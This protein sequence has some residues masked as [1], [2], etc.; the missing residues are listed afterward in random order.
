MAMVVSALLSLVAAVPAFAEDGLASQTKTI[1]VNNLQVNGDNKPTVSIYRIINCNYKTD[2]EDDAVDGSGQVGT[3]AYYWDSAIAAKLLADD[4]LKKWVSST[5]T[6][7]NKTYYGVADDFMKTENSTQAAAVYDQIRAWIGLG[8]AGGGITLTPVATPDVTVA[9]GATTGSVTYNATMGGYLIDVVGGP[10]YVYQTMVRTVY[11]VKGAN[12]TVWTLAAPDATVS[13]KNTKPS[14]TKTV[15]HASHLYYDTVGAQGA[16]SSVGAAIGDTLTYTVTLNVPTY[17]TGATNTKLE[18]TDVF[19]AGLTYV[20]DSLKVTAGAA[21]TV[22]TSDTAYTLT[23]AN[24]N[25]EPT[26]GDGST[27]TLDVLFDYPQVRGYRA[28]TVS[29]QAKVNSDMAAGKGSKNTATLTYANKPF[30]AS[31]T[32]GIS[33]ATTTYTYGMRVYKVNESEQALQGAKFVVIVPISDSLT[34]T[35]AQALTFTKQTVG[36]KTVYKVAG[37]ENVSVAS[38]VENISEDAKVESG[39]DGYIYIEGLDEGNYTLKEVEAPNGYLL[40]TG[41]FATDQLRAADSGGVITSETTSPVSGLTGYIGK[42][43]TN[44]SNNLILPVTGSAG[45]IIAVAAGVLVLAIG[46]AMVVRL[47]RRMRNEE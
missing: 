34:E 31:G 5:V 46:A 18:L 13:A 8:S 15:Q 11:P 30:D 47:R 35:N 20:K 7:D 42:T 32:E 39:A 43:I 9:S 12:A 28:I 36:S 27:T 37:V 44:T 4:N 41:Y 1:T 25:G 33:A 10:V 19:D 14:I 29:Y 45:T 6:L 24:T 21:S 26:P 23:Y 17:T 3:P 2:T 40:P 16:A 38:G 22:L